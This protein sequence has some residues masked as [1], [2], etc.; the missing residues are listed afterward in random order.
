M[1]NLLSFLTKYYHWLVFLIL[2]VV[3]G[4]MLFKYNSYQGSVWVST[5]N[6][7]AGKIYEWQAGVGHFFT[8]TRVNEEL[9]Q[10][11]LFLE[12]EVGRL[13]QTLAE[14]GADTTDLQRR[15]LAMLSQ[16]QLIPAK[17]VS[18]TVDKPDNLM[19]IDKGR[20]DGVATDMGV[21]CGNGLVGVVYLA[22]EHY[23]VVIP[24]VNKNSRI[25][26]SI[27]GRNYFGYLSWQGGS[28]VEAYLEDIPRHAK[29]KRGD[30]VETSGYSSIFPP[31]ILVGKIVAIYNS[32]D[33]MSYRLK[34]HLST[35][36]ACLRD[37][38]VI[39]DEGIAERMRLQEALRDSLELQKLRN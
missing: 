2:E 35:D 33:G 36:F 1:H 38:C 10:R 3:S 22:G 26:C 5:A 37:V 21:A 30:W 31:G 13:R 4:V 34:V 20:A 16:F 32:A 27:R 19:T 11:N 25:S 8:L 17:V 39:T 6:A 24:V 18:N 15:E 14:Q 28:P 7:V 29:F 23:S 12:Q 9:T